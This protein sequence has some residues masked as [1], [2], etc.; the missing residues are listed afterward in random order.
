MTRL[1][2]GLTTFELIA[3]TRV[4]LG[5]GL[6]LLLSRRLDE[7]TRTRVGAALVAIGAASTIP[8]L[9]AVKRARTL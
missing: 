6:G 8:A 1:D 4:A 7:R 5:A 2:L 3:V 9:V